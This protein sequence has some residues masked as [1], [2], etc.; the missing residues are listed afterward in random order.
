MSALTYQLFAALAGWLEAILYALR[1]AESF[2]SNEHRGMTWQRIAVVA[3]AAVAVA[4]FQWLGYWLA[5]E[6]VVAALLFP[7]V[8]D[9]FY[10]FTR[11]WLRWAEFYQKSEAL[12]TAAGRPSPP[13]SDQLARRDAWREYRYGYQSPTT[14][15]RNDFNGRQRSWLAIA[16]GALLLALYARFFFLS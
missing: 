2:S 15:A 8:H 6:V 13:N 3:T 7:L 11:L 16:G 5:V 10:N 14:T 4:E 9:E 12:N 1:G